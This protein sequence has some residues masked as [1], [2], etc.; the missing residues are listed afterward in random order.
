M[1]DRN[2]EAVP[3]SVT[4][5][6]AVFPVHLPIGERAGSIWC[7]VYVYSV[8]PKIHLWVLKFWFSF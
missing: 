1:N 6:P 3:E 8:V 5:P 4:I 2:A 7:I